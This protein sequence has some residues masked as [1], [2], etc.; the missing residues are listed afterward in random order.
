VGEGNDTLI[1]NGRSRHVIGYL[2][3]FLFTP[4]R[5]LSPVNILSGGEVAALNARLGALELE[6][7]EAY[8]RWEELEA[9]V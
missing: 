8:R 5:A 3:D 2:Q 7:A 9:L 6:L 4:E 1:I